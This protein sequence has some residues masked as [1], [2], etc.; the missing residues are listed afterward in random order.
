MIDLTKISNKKKSTKLNQK[1]RERKK[2]KMKNQPRN[3]KMMK[4]R[5]KSK[6]CREAFQGRSQ[7]LSKREKIK[8]CQGGF[9]SVSIKETLFRKTLK[10]SQ[11]L[12]TEHFNI[13]QGSHQPQSG[14]LESKKIFLGLLQILEKCKMS[15]M[16]MFDNTEVSKWPRPQSCKSTIIPLSRS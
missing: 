7:Q 11:M 13:R 3:S 2:K 12:Q 10:L 6:R 16:S 14:S 8:F 9:S 5:R 15:R 1:R 4:G